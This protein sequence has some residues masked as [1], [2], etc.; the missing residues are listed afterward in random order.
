MRVHSYY[1]SGIFLTV[2]NTTFSK[3][4]S[5]ESVLSKRDF[6]KYGTNYFE[7]SLPEA[8]ASSELSQICFVGPFFYLKIFFL[9]P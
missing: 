9:P 6:S 4:V 1:V 7:L 8:T 2:S 5:S 3:T